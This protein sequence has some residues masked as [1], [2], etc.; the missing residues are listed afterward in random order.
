[1]VDTKFEQD[2]DPV[3]RA[4]SSRY[5]SDIVFGLLLENR[6]NQ[7]YAEGVATLQEL[8]SVLRNNGRHFGGTV[9]TGCCSG[10]KETGGNG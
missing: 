7:I 2:M 3:L 8:I 4:M 5:S 1:M 6:R 9:H 10:H